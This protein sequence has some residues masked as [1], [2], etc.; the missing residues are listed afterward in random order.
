MASSSSARA[1]DAAK[2]ALTR[3]PALYNAL[4]R[5]YAIGR[6]MLRRPHDR[7][8][9]VFGL[10]PERTGLFLDVGANA[11]MSALSFRIYNRVSRIIAVEPNP[12]H[13]A[14]LRF[15]MRLARPFEYLIWAAG[16]EDGTMTLHVPLY[17]KVPL[18]TE[19]SLRMEQVTDSPHLQ[20]RLGA[21]MRTEDFEMESRTVPVRRLDVLKVDPS[22]IKLDVQG[23]EYEALL[24]LEHTVRRSKPILLVEGPD[25]SVRGF[26][27]D[28]GY[29]A[30]QYLPDSRKIVP[31]TKARTNT[32]FLAHKDAALVAAAPISGAV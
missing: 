15:T 12:F 29:E 13:E 18:T 30:F 31:E 32:L 7:D 1:I 25:D 16:S 26:L 4:R 6:F 23:F 2:V 14:D 27:A 10:F 11:G 21:G 17:R 22:F 5:P 8:Y 28:L 19:A 20:R 24:G 9:E 3:Y